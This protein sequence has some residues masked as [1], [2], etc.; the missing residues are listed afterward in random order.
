MIAAIVAVIEIKE[1]AKKISSFFSN[2]WD[3]GHFSWYKKF[4]STK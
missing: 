2:F 4:T 3:K 1:L